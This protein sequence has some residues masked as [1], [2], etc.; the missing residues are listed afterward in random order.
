MGA[1]WRPGA[2]DGLDIEALP[3]VPGGPRLAPCVGNVGKFLCIGLNYSDHAEEAGMPIPEHPILFLKA[4]SAISGPHDDI[5]LAARVRCHRL[6]S[7]A[8][9]CDREDREITSQ[10]PRRLIMSLGTV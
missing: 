9:R 6:G 2:L 8:G 7:G 3:I 4:N 5:L 1:H 10:K